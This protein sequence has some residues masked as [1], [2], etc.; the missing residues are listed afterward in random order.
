MNK[1]GTSSKA[2]TLDAQRRGAGA[3]GTDRG[4]RGGD[5]GDG[6][7]L[8]GETVPTTLGEVVRFGNGKAIK[9]GGTGRYPVYGSNGIIG[10]SDDF[11][12]ENG[13]II[14]RVGAYCGSVAYCPTPFWASD[15]TLVAYPASDEIDT[16]FL[17]YLLG[18]A[19]LRNYAGGAAQPL[20]TQTVLKQ[21]EVAV[22]G[23]PTQRRIAGILSAYDDL[24]EN[25]LRRIRILEEMA[26]SLYREWF[27]HFRFPGHD[28][29]SPSGRGRGGG[30]KPIPLV[31]SPLGPIPDG[32]E[33]KT[34]GEIAA[35]N[36]ETIRPKNAPD[37]IT[38][39]DI[40]SVSTGSVDNAEPMLF[41]DAPSRAR[42]IVRQGD[43]IWSTVR[44]NRR[45][46]A[47]ILDP[48]DDLVVSTG[49]AVLSARSIPSS[50]LYQA[51][52]T[53]DFT[54]YL[55]N[56]ATGAAYPAVNAS[57][58]EAADFLVPP[59]D[60]LE[61]FNAVV[62]RCLSLRASL[63]CRNQTLRQTRDLLLPKLLSNP[64]SS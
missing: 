6:M 7:N 38:Y 48:V 17:Y 39:I 56:R 16:R 21:V 35:V 55:V 1:T 61:Q 41:A 60:L 43:V 13:V 33:V 24:I 54:A 51:A 62:G 3:G 36:A 11:R 63:Q 53:D 59:E 4:K 30:A 5:S 8:A 31:D 58:F 2:G 42:R 26:Q 14:G 57:I 45:S 40:A 12:H 50:Y 34:L 19:N 44:P 10:G 29:S 46:F 37:E 18:S 23:L 9:P 52:T 22:P 15:N 27:V 64:S 49:F 25:N 28:G 32:W 47:L 20:V